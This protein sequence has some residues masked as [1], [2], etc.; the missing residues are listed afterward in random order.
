MTG[1]KIDFCVAI[2][3]L[4]VFEL[5]FAATVTHFMEDLAI[6]ATCQVY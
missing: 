5:G 3:F 2:F 1:S 6:V 4:F